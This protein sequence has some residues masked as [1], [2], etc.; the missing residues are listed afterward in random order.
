MQGEIT[1]FLGHLQAEKGF[2][3]NTVAAYQNDLHQLLSF[4]QNGVQD[5]GPSSPP[6]LWQA[7]NQAHIQSFIATLHSRSYAETTVARKIA[8][9]KSFFHF[10]LNENLIPSNPADSLSTPGVRRSLPK[11]ISVGEVDKLL[12]QTLKRETPEARRDWAMLT[13]LCA[14][15]MR[16]TELV[17]LNVEDVVLDRNYPH[18][19]CVGRASRPR[20]IPLPEESIESIREYL[21]GARDQLARR[22]EERG[23]FLNRRG[24]R[25]T[26]QGFWLILKSY[27][28]AANLRSEITPHMLRHTFAAHMLQS[29][30][31]NLRELQEFLG[32]ASI[33]TTQV[34]THIPN[35][36][37]GPDVSKA[38]PSANR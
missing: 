26:R 35:G 2:S 38:A 10:L 7:V 17:K 20:L 30:R 22:P 37:A 12:G 21:G 3:P 9:L 29:G 36:Q 18:V 16:V 23:L 31:L 1:R 4:V 8:S 32:H 5:E 19:R 14:T 27:A 28:K 33:T 11:T 25:L 15:G 34:Y 6:S 24:E 13:L